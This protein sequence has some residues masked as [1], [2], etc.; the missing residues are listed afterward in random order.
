MA[1]SSQLPVS[2]A[3]SHSAS[4]ACLDPMESFINY[5]PVYPSPSLSPS[6]K[7]KAPITQPPSFATP[8]PVTVPSQLGNAQNFN[9][10]SHRYDLHPQQT[11]L[12]AGGLANTIAVNEANM[13]QF[14][15]MSDNNYF[16][17]NSTPFDFDSMG[18]F[19]MLGDGTPDMDLELDSPERDL[20]PSMYSQN[21]QPECVD[22]SAVGGQDSSG[23]PTIPSQNF[24][25]AW[26][27]MHQQQAALAKA[28]A[29]ARQQKQ[30]QIINQQRQKAQA[31]GGHP[32]GSNAYSPNDPMVEERIS[33]LLSQMRQS[34][35][36]SYDENASSS[37]AMPHQV[38]VKKDE[39]DM[40]EDERLLNSEEG[41][42]LSSKER[43]QLRNK[44]SARAFRSRRK[45]Y[46]SQLEGE[47]AA[48]TNE[49][50]DLKIH[51]RALMEENKRLS[52]L[53]RMLL[54]SSA[55]SGFLDNL[56]NNGGVLPAGMQAP[57]QMTS[58]NLPKDP[59]PHHLTQQQHNMQIGMTLVP[60]TTMDFN[61]LSIDNNYNYGSG[62]P[63]NDAQV[64]ALTSIPEGPA[65]DHIDSGILS[66]KTSSSVLGFSDDEKDQT[67]CVETPPTLPKAVE[68]NEPVAT[69]DPEIEL[70]ES[71]PHFALFVDSPNTPTS[72]EMGKVEE[73]D[74]TEELFGSIRV[75]K[76]FSRIELVVGDDY[77]DGEIS[78]AA[79]DRA[80]GV[81]WRLMR[82]YIQFITTPTSDTSGT[83][84][85][86]HFENK[87]Y[88]LGNIGEGTS[89]AC[90][91]RGV[92][93][94]K[95]S[96]FFLTGRTEWSS[97]GGL[98]GMIL[99]LAD[100]TNGS[101]AS[102]AENAEKKRIRREQFQNG[103]K[104]GIPTKQ[105]PPPSRTSLTI[106][107][108]MNLTH[109]LA[110]ARRF[111]FRKGM[112][113]KVHELLG[114]IDK[115][116][117]GPREPNWTD[118]NVKIWAMPIS[119]STSQSEQ[120]HHF[121]CPSSLRKRSWDEFDK[122]VS[123]DDPD[124]DQ[125]FRNAIVHEMFNSEWR[126]DKLVETPLKDIHDGANAYL[127]DPMTNKL[128][129]LKLPGPGDPVPN[130]T[131][132]ARQPWPGAIVAGLPPT[133]PSKESVSYIIKT[134]TR[135]GKFDAKKAEE[136]KIRPKDRGMLTRGESVQST[137]GKTITPEMVI[138]EDR[139]GCGIAVIDLPSMEYVENLIS[140]PEWKDLEIM[141]GIAAIIWI[142]GPGV[143]RD[144]RLRQF[145]EGMDKV[146]HIVSSRDHCPN[147]LAFT[148]AASSAIQLHQI[149]KQRF[150][151]PVHD[152]TT[153]PQSGYGVPDESLGDDLLFSPAKRGEMF[154]LEPDTGSSN[155]E[156]VP[157]LNTAEVVRKTPSE[158]LALARKAQE[159]V[160]DPEFKA[161]LKKVQADIPSQDAE[162]VTLGTGSA[163]PSK[164][165]NVSA[166]LLRVPGF[167]SYLFDCGENTLGQLRRV[168]TPE[169]LTEIL[170]DLKMIW[171][172]HLHADHH[173]GTT[174]VIKAWYQTVHGGYSTPGPDV[175]DPSSFSPESVLS[176]ISSN[177][178]N[179]RLA[180]ISDEGMISWL[181]E[182]ASVEDFGYSRVMPIAAVAPSGTLTWHGHAVPVSSVASAVG[183]SDLHATPVDHCKGAL[184]LTIA[185][186]SGLKVGY[187][188]DCRPCM[189]WAR[190]HLSQNCHLL[191][192]EATFDDELQVDAMAKKHST[193]SEALTVACAMKN[194]RAI[195]T[196][197]SQR[198]QKLPVLNKVKIKSKRLAEEEGE[199]T[200]VWGE[201]KDGVVER[202]RMNVA[203]QAY[204]ME[205]DGNTSISVLNA[206]TARRGSM[207]SGR[208]STS[209]PQEGT[210][211]RGSQRPSRRSNTSSRNSTRSPRRQQ[212]EVAGYS[213]TTSPRS[214]DMIMKE[215]QDDQEMDL[216]LK[217]GVA[218]D[219]MRVKL[220]EIAELEKLEP[221]LTKLFEGK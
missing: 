179:K 135:R 61:T 213:S 35:V 183:L 82:S 53:T 218:F 45:E 74:D 155:A 126:M 202:G 154:H 84:I 216:D 210:I 142:L 6:S 99:N 90:I 195:L 59:N 138:G 39:E 68:S 163:L 215:A 27:G 124:R 7:G 49:A 33:R 56:S 194:R 145:C 196:H 85:L 167:G 15:M 51:N 191:I 89:R 164:Y 180:V 160:S 63:V 17:M 168:F 165:R 67:P 197:F 188:G 48:R 140:R 8:Q 114:S 2:T 107:G 125:K 9:G 162:I 128:K 36:V 176:E 133:K 93:L 108:A 153:L 113:V 189:Q 77:D 86:L 105:E 98:I 10:P 192:H 143:S 47:I 66:E 182:Y 73:V 102:I 70:D 175:T 13:Q 78:A 30:Q 157:F 54:S 37:N 101:A 181:A 25:R 116:L 58:Q 79:M 161:H 20:V 166:T 150:F 22:P 29:Q 21:S 42:K 151:V 186:P 104:K 41:K 139:P 198:Y 122:E 219:Y 94:G 117:K 214:T 134:Y 184:A 100:A 11:G 69:P 119:P 19:P 148:S 201:E 1:T 177:S 26:P 156:T 149:D 57:Q 178:E 173:L 76:V 204:S 220:G 152:N 206:K 130:I 131:V 111:I 31:Q 169:Q 81:N 185:F 5:D 32:S 187:S 50:N 18:S 103:G 137:D 62:L 112:P 83:T 208:R 4:N 92:K 75:E 207:N 23:A 106:H 171:I 193:T 190:H 97:T 159:Q 144:E 52:D 60:E 110:T 211:L 16:G 221:A 199:E 91:Q 43:R 205:S 24:Q 109:S 123:A 141:K 64:Y 65:V 38:R 55:F 209:P 87:R 46:I 170:H 147:Y 132:L 71:D 121:P 28:Q 95:V 118:G 14:N 174:S 80:R 172:S 72:S 212:H 200:E 129:R 146:K 88:L 34:S 96:D 158:V 127:L 12:P 40:D 217:V 203:G 44:V 136:L 120:P 3:A 115:D